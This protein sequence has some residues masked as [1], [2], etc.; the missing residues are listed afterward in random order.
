MMRLRRFVD[1]LRWRTFLL[2]KRE[3]ALLLRRLGLPVSVPVLPATS[4]TGEDVAADE[5]SRTPWRALPEQR[6]GADG[7]LDD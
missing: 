5:V 1:F 4:A 7:G 6:G 2:A 3:A